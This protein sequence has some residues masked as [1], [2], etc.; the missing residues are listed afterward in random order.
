M[1][2]DVSHTRPAA[3]LNPDCAANA[4]ASHGDKIHRP[5]S[6]ANKFM[7]IF[8]RSPSGRALTTPA[9]D[10]PASQA[11]DDAQYQNNDNV[12]TIEVIGNVHDSDAGSYVDEGGRHDTRS[13]RNSQAGG[14]DM[15]FQK[16]AFGRDSD[17]QQAHAADSAASADGKQQQT[18]KMR[19]SSSRALLERLGFEG[20]GDPASV[21][22]GDHATEGEGQRKPPSRRSS[23]G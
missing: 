20:G 19:R 15:L 10:N 14:G 3:P 2:V 5:S 17:V 16:L 21:A 9:A 22:P 18:T 6:G 1:I 12:T 8:K 13:W 23:S 11:G 7:S 4:A